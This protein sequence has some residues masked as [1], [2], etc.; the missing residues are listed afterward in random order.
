MARM[1]SGMFP[2]PAQTDQ[3]NQLEPDDSATSDMGKILRLSVG[4]LSLYSGQ[5]GGAT[6]GSTI[7]VKYHSVVLP[8]S[9]VLHQTQV[10]MK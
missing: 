10:V 8:L 6:V 5:Y 3:G 9:A 2:Q 4:L 7:T 1:I